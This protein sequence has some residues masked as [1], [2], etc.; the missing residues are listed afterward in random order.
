MPSPRL[1]PTHA[2]HVNIL[3]L[4]L[5]LTLTLTRTQDLHDLVFIGNEATKGA[6]VKIKAY[7]KKA[8]FNNWILTDNKAKG[9]FGAAGGVYVDQNLEMTF[10]YL[11]ATANSAGWKGGSFFIANSNVT[12]WD[13]TFLANA[14]REGA[15]LA[16]EMNSNLS[17]AQTL[18]K[19]NVAVEAGGGLNVLTSSNT[20][21]REC[22]FKENIV[23]G[24]TGLTGGSAFSALSKSMVNASDTLFEDNS[25]ELGCG[26]HSPSTSPSLSPSQSPSPS[27]SLSGAVYVDDAN[28]QMARNTITRNAAARGM[29]GEHQC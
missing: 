27:P 16:V 1:P 22:I 15:G 21:I 12:V 5:A 20:Q 8:V 25:V 13:S 19:G 9:L 10:N 18:F 11:N 7:P 2:R 23:T 26:G 14:A 6:A 17:V 4:T 29:G 24:V 28:L 3:T